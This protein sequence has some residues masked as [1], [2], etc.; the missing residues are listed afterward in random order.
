MLNLTNS[1]FIEEIETLCRTK[2][3]EY[4]DA[5]I[6]WCERNKQEVEFAAAIIKKDP[7]FKSKL[8]AEAEELNYLPKKAKLPFNES[9]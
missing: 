1:N 6:D 2:N 9:V 8:Q 3:I 7:V 5:I 4:I